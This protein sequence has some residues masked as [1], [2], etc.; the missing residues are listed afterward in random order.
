[1]TARLLFLLNRIEQQ[2]WLD[3]GLSESQSLSLLLPNILDWPCGRT[4]FCMRLLSTSFLVTGPCLSQ[5]QQR[6]IKYRV[7]ETMNTI[8]AR[9]KWAPSETL[10]DISSVELK[11][12]L[13]PFIQPSLYWPVRIRPSSPARYGVNNG[14]PSSPK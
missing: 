5:M 2:D 7:S 3:S 10:D 13:G 6:N 4:R 12:K 11:L 8:M 14:N 9:T 1:M